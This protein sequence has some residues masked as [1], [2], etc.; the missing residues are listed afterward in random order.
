[1]RKGIDITI[2]IRLYIEGNNVTT[3]ELP[4]EH[5]LHVTK[6]KKTQ[7]MEK[8]TKNSRFKC[9]VADATVLKKKNRSVIIIE[10]NLVE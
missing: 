4:L 3:V 1:M 8:V 5:A 9:S 2:D 10:T 7:Q 6:E